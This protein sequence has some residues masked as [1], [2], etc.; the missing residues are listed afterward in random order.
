MVAWRGRMAEGGPQ[1]VRLALV[2]AMLFF[3]RP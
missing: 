3:H 2:V 1:Y